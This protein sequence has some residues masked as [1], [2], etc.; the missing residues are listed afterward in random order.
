MIDFQKNNQQ[1]KLK[2]I[3]LETAYDE[4]A[5]LLLD[6][7]TVMD[8]YAT[9]RDKLVFTDRRIISADHLDGM[10]KRISYS[11][12]PYSRIQYFT[13]QTAGLNELFDG[14]ELHLYFANGFDLLFAISGRVDIAALG[15]LISQYVLEG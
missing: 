13:V 8:A 4:V 9:I 3:D 2:P 1:I 7:E 12:I 15:R 10:R 5:P 6:E 14:A 11:T